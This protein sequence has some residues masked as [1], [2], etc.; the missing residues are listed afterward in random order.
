MVYRNVTGE[1][2]GPCRGE[3]ELF[4]YWQCGTEYHSAVDTCPGEYKQ[5]VTSQMEWAVAIGWRGAVSA[6]QGEESIRSGQRPDE[7]TGTTYVIM[8]RKF[9]RLAVSPNSYE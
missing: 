4:Q 8:R 1:V 9:E 7:A 2:T 5:R 3:V 6:E